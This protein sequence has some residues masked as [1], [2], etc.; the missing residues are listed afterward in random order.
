MDL[1][2]LLALLM[3]PLSI[4]AGKAFELLAAAVVPTEGTQ[5]WTSEVGQE[6]GVLQ[7][8]TPWFIERPETFGFQVLKI[9]TPLEGQNA[10]F[11][12]LSTQFFWAGV[13]LGP[14]S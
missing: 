3:M 1:R 12:W 10:Y 5:R 2:G 4:A 13:L 6:L 9:H 11:L 7:P 8:W 14:D